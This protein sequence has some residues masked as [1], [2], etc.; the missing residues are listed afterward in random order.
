[1][2]FMSSFQ[3]SLFLWVLRE[4]KKQ[5]YFAL[6][7]LRLKTEELHVNTIYFLTLEVFFE[8]FHFERPDDDIEHRNI[9]G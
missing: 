3:D 9:N 4:K 8:H 2:D 1:M 5:A 6:S 7:F